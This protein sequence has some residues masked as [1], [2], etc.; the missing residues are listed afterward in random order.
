MPDRI[1]VMNRGRVEQVG[2]PDEIYARPATA[3]VTDFV[4]KMNFLEGRL[5][6]PVRADVAG[7]AL[8]LAE[9]VGLGAGAPVT[10]C[11]RPEG[12]VVRGVGGGR[13][14]TLKVRVG[15]RG[16]RRQPLRGRAA[17][18]AQA[19]TSRSTTCASSASARAPRS[20]WRCR[21]PKVWAASSTCSRPAS[22]SRSWACRPSRWAPWSGSCSSCP[23]CSPSPL[24]GWRSGGRRRCSP[25]AVPL[26]PKPNRLMD[27]GLFAFCATVAAAI[28]VA[29]FASLAPCRPYNLTP[30]LWRHP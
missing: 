15:G 23:P 20:R 28:L 27:G 29:I 6:G 21:V 13:P 10:V 12:I 14:N 1:A 24:T 30:R 3:F 22:T 7:A 9:P 16:V 8:E 25:R 26:V 5:L 11:V 18:A 2:T 19:P 17:R 4:G